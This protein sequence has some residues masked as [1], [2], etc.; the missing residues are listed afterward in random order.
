MVERRAM[1]RAAP[2]PLAGLA[3]QLLLLA[4]L[5]QT[6]GL[7]RAGWVVGVTSGLILAAGW[8][9]AWMAAPLPRRDW[10]KVVT[11]GQGIALTVAAAGILPRAIA[12]AALAAALALLAESFGRDV[13]WLWRHRAAL[14]LQPA[15]RP[16]A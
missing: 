11:A 12:G 10:R 9:F 14:Q 1:L 3:A 8:L 6:V 15:A 4:T 5:A 16:R 13:W 7:G 2:A